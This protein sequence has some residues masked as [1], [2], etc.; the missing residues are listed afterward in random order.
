M[1][2]GFDIGYIL[3]GSVYR[4]L[5]KQIPLPLC[6]DSRSLYHLAISLGRTTEH[7]LLNDSHMM[8]EVFEK[9]DITNILWL[10]GK[11]NP[12]DGLNE[13]GT[14]ENAALEVTV[15]RNNFAQKK[16]SCVAG[17]NVP[18]RTNL[19]YS[20][21]NTALSKRETVECRGN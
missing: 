12:A 19:S 17:E 21:M 2:E 4:V 15:Q 18:V 11:S 3:K 7:R 20:Y 9:R 6:T 1:V 13:V 10:S 14:A 8:R 16:N 5:G